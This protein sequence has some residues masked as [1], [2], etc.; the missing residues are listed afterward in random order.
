[1]VG[2]EKRTTLI[3]EEKELAGTVK[4]SGWDEKNLRGEEGGY[5][6]H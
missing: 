4:T 3:V 2:V 6:V 5:G 1:V